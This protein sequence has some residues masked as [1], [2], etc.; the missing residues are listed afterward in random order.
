MKKF[1]S[2][3]L[4]VVLAATFGVS[5][6]ASEV[7]HMRYEPCSFCGNPLFER[8]SY[9]DWTNTG[10]TRHTPGGY[11]GQYDME[12]VRDVRIYWECVQCNKTTNQYSYKQTRWHTL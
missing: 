10:N 7:S 6:F 1:I 5:A 4:A 9:S 8:T 2:I 12:Q 3:V 11:E